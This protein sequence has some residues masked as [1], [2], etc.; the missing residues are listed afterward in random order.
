M[1]LLVAHTTLLEISHSGSNVPA[2]YWRYGEKAVCMLIYV[3]NRHSG[4]IFGFVNYLL[5]NTCE[6]WYLNSRSLT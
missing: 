5:S 6:F 4:H 2:G 3:I 1:A